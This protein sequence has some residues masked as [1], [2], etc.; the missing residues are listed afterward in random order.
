M[1]SFSK[2]HTLPK[3]QQGTPMGRIA[4][5][6]KI[7]ELTILVCG[8][9]LFVWLTNAEQSF[10]VASAQEMTED[11]NQ[12]APFDTQLTTTYQVLPDGNTHVI[13]DFSVKNTSPTH[14]LNQYGLTISF[15]DLKNIVV[16]NNGQEIEP[17]IT[18]ANNA[19]SVSIPFPDQIVGEGKIRNFSVEYDTADV[20]TVAN[21][22]LEVQIPPINSQESFTTQSVIL[23]TPLKFG[24]AV[25]VSPDPSAAGIDNDGIVTKFDQSSPQPISAFYG[26]EQIFNVVLRYN[27]E[28]NSS[29]RGL[30]QVALPPDTPYQRMYYH[31]LDP[32]T[33]QLK[34]DE[35]GNWLAT[36][37]L[38]PNTA[39]SV[40]LTADVLLTLEPNGIV[41][42][43]KPES[44]HTSPDKY[45]DISQ[46]NFNSI[47]D[48]VTTAANIYDYVVQELNYSYDIANETDVQ[49]RLGAN[50]ALNNPDQA[51]CQEFTDLFIALARKQNIPARRLTGF[52]YTQ[53]PGL[54]PLSLEKD[55]LHSWPEFFDVETGLWRPVDPTWEDTTGGID[56]FNHF[57]LNH[58]V[59]AINGQSSSTPYPAGA[60]KGADLDT[61]DVE[62][63]FSD[64]F[65]SS[66]PSYD[67]Q[68]VPE[69]LFGIEV[70][71]R[72]FLVITNQTGQA[73]YDIAVN[74]NNEQRVLV[75]DTINIVSIPILLPYQ[76]VT[77][78]VSLTDETWQ[79]G[80]RVDINYQVNTDGKVTQISPTQ[81][82]LQTGPSYLT[83]LSEEVVYIGV[84]ITALFG[85]FIAGSVLVLRSKR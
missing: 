66:E 29:S 52:A 12:S 83:N 10:F 51:V 3:W 61:K 85:I 7:L 80:K 21:K 1:S 32:F 57:D 40:Y 63:S 2:S 50:E 48:E 25:R 16:K 78:P 37:E 41:P 38:N 60:Y 28:N 46:K 5:A 79:P 19:T 30:A 31:S 43:L 8:L 17:E 70:P 34:V 67:F 55:I 15:P 9:V 56:Y 68:F 69:K 20:A 71:G 26:E 64:I 13:Q 4:L 82:E 27:L 65:P 47:T 76:T 54:R 45:W 39:L 58:I 75:D 84:V 74:F 44:F 14:Y 36:Y 24:R 35:D 72:Y 59:F 23:K 33:D 62:V 73:W 81:A 53:N 11:E 77:L 6:R 49:A 18:T 22:V 42:Q